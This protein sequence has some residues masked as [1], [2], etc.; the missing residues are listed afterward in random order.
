[1]ASHLFY[2][3]FSL[4]VSGTILLKFSYFYE[5][6]AVACGFNLYFLMVNG[7]ERLFL[8]LLCWPFVYLL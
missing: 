7:I 6:V 2:I 3:P 1:M 4:Q 5:C 8:R